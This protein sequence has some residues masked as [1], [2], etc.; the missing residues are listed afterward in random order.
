MAERRPPAAT[1]WNRLGFDASRYFTPNVP[2][3]ENELFAAR[4]D[5]VRRVCDAINQRG[6]H[7]IVYGERGVGKTSLAN[8]LQF[9]IS[10][11]TGELPLAPRINCDSL[12]TFA[13][14]WKKIFSQVDL[15]R[16]QRQIGFQLRIFEDTVR[17]ADVVPDSLT[18]EDIK[19]LLALLG[20][21]KLVY[22]I[23]DEF[24]R[25]T[26][27]AVRRAMAD[28]IKTLSDN[29]IKATMIVIGVAD[30]IEEL[31]AEHESIDRAIK[32]IK[33]PRMKR[34][35]VN[36]L[37][38]KGMAKLGMRAT[39]QAQLRLALL[40][41]GLPHYA[42][43]LGLHA[44]RAAID[45]RSLTVEEKHVRSAIATAAEDSHHMIRSDFQKAVTSPQ[46]G[47]L[48]SEVLLAC[49]MAETD[50]FGFFYPADVAGPLAKIMKKPREIA[51][52]TQHLKDFCSEARGPVL[53][54]RGEKRKFRYRFHNPLLQPMIIMKGI[55]DKK[56]SEVDLEE[57][58]K[59][60]LQE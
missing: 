32:Q 23:F 3:S 31:I 58:A 5:E 45:A 6:Q 33:M 48:Y 54:Q 56:I 57:E 15:I 46:K 21:D 2:V 20:D 24:D 11:T 1:D 7:A 40:C 26:D 30:D 25:V 34:E 42:Q 38:E 51:H 37:L 36:E 4:R 22:L 47:N 14:L 29:A 9:R 27:P 49:A 13:S 10:T 39:P 43:L 35:A 8:I 52:F 44:V 17:A 60:R 16:Q 18:P 12:D 50:E 41:Q 59:R 55:A 19:R 53:D 28:T